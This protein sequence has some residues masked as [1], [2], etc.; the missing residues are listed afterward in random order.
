VSMAP[1]SQVWPQIV[2]DTRGG[3]LVLWEDNRAGGYTYYLYAQHLDENGIPILTLNGIPLYS[4]GTSMQLSCG[5]LEGGEPDDQNGGVFVYTTP[6]ASNLL[7]VIRVNGDGETQW[8]WDNGISA[9]HF[10]GDPLKNPADG[11]IWIAANDNRT[12]GY[13]S[14]LYHLD[15]DGNP[16][17]NPAGII[18]GETMAPTSDGAIAFDTYQNSLGTRIVAKRSNGAGRQIWECVVALARL[19]GGGAPGLCAISS[20]EDGD[21]GAVITMLDI[22]LYPSEIMNIAAQRVQWNGHLGN[23]I[24]AHETILADN[25]NCQSC[26]AIN[27]SSHFQR[28]ARSNWSC[29]TC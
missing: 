13:Q 8:V 4:P 3:A 5:G 24:A 18:G 26:Q 10:V 15:I 22:R 21:D 23:P 27:C 29:S 11:T 2:S 6:G 28:Q 14:Y 7:R 25:W 16:L 19:Y 1:G 9:Q 12:G 17:F 20:S